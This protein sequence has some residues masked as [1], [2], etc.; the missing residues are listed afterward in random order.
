VPAAAI[1]FL[2]F[3]AFMV[4]ADRTGFLAI[5]RFPAW[6]I[7]CEAVFGAVVADPPFG[8]KH[9]AAVRDLLNNR[10]CASDGE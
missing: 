9:L 8:M 6:S 5:W 3:T 10:V 2:L 1:V 4:G 7:V